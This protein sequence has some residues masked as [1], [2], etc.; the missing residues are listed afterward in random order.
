MSAPDCKMP[1]VCAAEAVV[2][3]SCTR[4]SLIAPLLFGT[5]A[6]A[7]G[8]GFGV[9]ANPV[10]VGAGRVVVAVAVGVAETPKYRFFNVTPIGSAVERAVADALADAVVEAGAALAE[11]EVTDAV[12]DIMLLVDDEEG[13][14]FGLSREPATKMMM[15]SATAMM[16]TMTAVP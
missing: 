7:L 13:A 6:V 11:E 10:A 3:V 15:I 9:V 14:A 8:F 4:S 16:P 1:N 5:V 2:A 12:D